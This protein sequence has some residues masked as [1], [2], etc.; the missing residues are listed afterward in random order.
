MSETGRSDRP[1][2]LLIVSL[3]LNVALVAL[4]AA[5]FFRVGLRPFE[6]HGPK[7]A[8]SAP[9]LMRMVPAEETKIRAVL[10][11]HRP[12]LHQLH[13]DA[14]QARAEL[15]QVLS[16]PKF[17]ADSFAKASGAVES[18]DSALETESLNTTAE[19]I[20]LLTP[21]ERAHVASEVHKPGRTWLRHLVRKH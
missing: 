9:A 2:I 16:A 5:M 6:A 14:M 17:D 1:S 15:F 3:C 20:G 8:L 12:R 13:R 21:Q 18:A 7:G 19:A 4:C 10:D 11:A